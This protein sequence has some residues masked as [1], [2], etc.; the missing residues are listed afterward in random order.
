VNQAR[1]LFDNAP[2]F[3]IEQNHGDLGDT[4]SERVAAG[5]F[6][7]DDGVHR[8]RLIYCLPQRNKTIIGDVAT[9]AAAAAFNGEFHRQSRSEV[10]LII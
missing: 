7:I 8:Q 6:K 4:V 9:F 5:G 1:E 10:F 3:C 2:I